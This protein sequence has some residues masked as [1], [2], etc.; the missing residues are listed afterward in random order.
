MGHFGSHMEPHWA[1]EG[2]GGLW[3]KQACQYDSKKV[4]TISV[5]ITVW[6]QWVIVTDEWMD[7]QKDTQTQLILRFR[8]YRLLYDGIL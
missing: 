5:A 2:L 4:C 7:G 3:L 1:P 8:F 6:R